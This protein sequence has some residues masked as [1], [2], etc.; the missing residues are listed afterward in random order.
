MTQADKARAFAALHVK[1]APLVLYNIWDAGSARAVAEAGARALATG[2]ASVAGAHG[3]PDGEAIPL[4]L[5]ET[6]VARI[7]ASVD[8][9]VSVDFEGAYATEPAAAAD[10]VARLIG[11]GAI[12]INFED[13]VIGGEGLHD[14]AAQAAR[15][16]AVRAA[17]EALDV[18]LF[19][20]ARTDLFLKKRT[21]PESHAG[22]MAEAKERAAAYAEAGASGF[23]AP[24]LFDEEL[25][26]ELCAATDLPVNIIMLPGAPA[27]KRLGELGVARASYGPVP[28]RVLMAELT[29]RARDALGTAAG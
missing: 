2:S 27:V 10:N 16:A 13:Q 12:G 23:F 18:P 19:I 26:A 3:Y 17:A 15:I 5:L 22:L 21:E 29:A 25:I 24:V 7:A 6:V 11:A 14:I 1:G 20:N 9:P 28:F 4:D 8:L